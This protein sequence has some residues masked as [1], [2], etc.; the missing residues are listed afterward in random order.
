MKMYKAAIIGLG[1]IASTY[2]DE[3]TRGGMVLLPYAHAP[4]YTHSPFTKLVSGA[5]INKEQRNFFAQKWGLPINNIYS[6]YKDMLKKENPD[7]VS[8]CTSTRN[9]PDILKYVAEFGVKAIWLEK[10]IAF[11]LKDADEMVE[12]CN[13]NNIVLAVNCSRRWNPMYSQARNIIESGHIGKILQIN[14]I[15]ECWISHNGSH[16]IDMVRFLANSEVD[17]VIGDMESQLDAEND[18]DFKA[19]AYLAFKNGTRAFIRSMNS[20]GLPTSSWSFEVIGEKGRIR[21]PNDAQS[22]ELTSFTT[23]SFPTEDNRFNSNNKHPINH[24][25]PWPT[26][27]QGTGL[28]IIEDIISSIDNSHNPKCT[29]QDGIKALE[30]AIAIRESF[31][32]GHQKMNL[33]LKNRSL[34]IESRET[35]NDELPAR[36]RE[37]NKTK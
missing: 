29:G 23:N 26:H 8:I 21:T 7:I 35:I 25:F 19:N 18:K 31:R 15:A 10:P 14:A 4:A 36:I 3:K 5:D 30:I 17:W 37:Q 20:G 1:R 2:D 24:Q 28:T 32:N 27:I 12:I 33:P 9:R 11:S 6:D 16:L 13:R 34:K 22:W